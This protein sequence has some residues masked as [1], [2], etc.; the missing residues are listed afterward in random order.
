M[1]FPFS[2][3]SKIIIIF[4]FPLKSAVFNNSSEI[5][6]TACLF[7]TSALLETAF[8]IIVIITVTVTVIN[9]N[10]DELPILEKIII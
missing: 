5:A 10:N 6:V 7:L 2:D 4:V 8:V 1:R 9:D 3:L